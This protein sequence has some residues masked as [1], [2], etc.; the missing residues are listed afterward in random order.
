MAQYECKR[1]T[2][3][4][5]HVDETGKDDF[6]IEALDF[7]RYRKNPVILHQH[8]W[9]GPPIGYFKDLDEKDFSGVPVF[10]R[11]DPVSESYVENMLAGVMV[12]YYPGGF[13]N[14]NRTRFEVMEVSAFIPPK[15]LAP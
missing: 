4:R 3:I 5:H 12:E 7:K 9:A 8:D 14:K 15:S 6:P 1:I 13:W 10:H 11:K 2:V